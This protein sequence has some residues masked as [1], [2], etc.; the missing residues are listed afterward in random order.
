MDTL[1]GR[2]EEHFLG[3]AARLS[4]AYYGRQ[5]LDCN[6]YNEIRAYRILTE[7]TR[8]TTLKSPTLTVTLGSVTR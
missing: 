4:A 1:A 6:N 7:C 5:P 2:Q 3:V 8:R